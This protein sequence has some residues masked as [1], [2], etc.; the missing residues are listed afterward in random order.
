[1]ATASPN[2]AVPAFVMAGSSGSSIGRAKPTGSSVSGE[3]YPVVS[4]DSSTV[5]ESTRSH[6][7]ADT[8]PSTLARPGFMPEPKMLLPPRSQAA[9]RRA[10]ASAPSA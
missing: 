3:S 8:R 4:T 1:M 9:W 7:P 2:T 10:R 5:I 6:T